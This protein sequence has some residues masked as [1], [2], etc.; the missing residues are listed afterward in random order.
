MLYDSVTDYAEL[1]PED[2]LVATAGMTVEAAAALLY[3]WAF[4]RRPEQAMPPGEWAVWLICAGRGFGKTR[5]GV[6]A[7]RELVDINAGCRVALVGPTSADCRDVMIEGESGLLAIYPPEERPIYQPS[8]RK[9]TFRNGAQ[10]FV[11]SAEEPERLR[12]P[13]HHFAYCD[14]IAVYG[15]LKTLWDNL[16]FGLRLGETPR[17]VA[18][19]TPRP[20][21][22]LRDLARDTGTHTTRGTTY[23]NAAHLPPAFLA[24]LDRVYTGTTI[25]RQE[26]L[27][28]LLEEAEGALWRRS[29]IEAKRVRAAPELTRIVVAIDPA[30]TSGENSDECGIV[31]AGVGVDGEGYVLS[32]GTCRLPPDQWAARAVNMFDTLDA[33]KI[34]AETNNGGDL[35]ESVIRTVRRNVSY[36]KVSASRGKV[37]RAEPVAALYEQGKVHHVGMFAALEEEMVNF[38]PGQMTKSPNRADALVWALTFLML[39]KSSGRAW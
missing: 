21:P 27:G 38:V 5:T 29:Q 2:L 11:Y 15:D 23:A 8:K 30:T 33:D 1:E 22:F 26:L 19:T 25:G 7:V 17:I 3:S 37:T 14:E 10:A 20:L 32:D 34:I 28:E 35:V 36:E 13:Q 12:G 24:E 39:K 31:A 16:K 4:W 9:V 18:T 6:E